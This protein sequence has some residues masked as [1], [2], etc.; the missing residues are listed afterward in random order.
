MVGLACLVLCNCGAGSFKGTCSFLNWL[1]RV[2]SLREEKLW[3]RVREFKQASVGFPAEKFNFK[4]QHCL[5][6]GI[7][8]DAFDVT[9]LNRHGEVLKSI[10]VP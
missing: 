8:V 3:L 5:S 2:Q 7:F 9:N 4:F 10:A 1:R 6:N